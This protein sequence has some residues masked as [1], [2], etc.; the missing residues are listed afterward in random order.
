ME[1][2]HH[3]NEDYQK[4]INFS[5]S[6]LVFNPFDLRAINSQLYALEN[7]K[8]NKVFE[9]RLIQLKVI[10][11]ALISSGYGTSKEEAFYV[12]YTTHEYDL[13]SF[14]GFEFGGLNP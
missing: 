1:K 12:I 7:L 13:L 10:K 5:D 14:L 2:E 6:A 8:N 11:N 3:D 9:K 4:I